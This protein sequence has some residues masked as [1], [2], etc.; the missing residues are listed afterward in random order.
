MNAMIPTQ[1]DERGPSASADADGPSGAVDTARVE[2]L[3]RELLLALGEDPERAGLADTPRRVAGWWREFLEPGSAGTA[4]CFA[5]AS[6]DGQLVVVGDMGVWSLCEHHLLPM[7][8]DVTVGYLPAGV[9]LG[10]SKFGRITRRFAGRLQLQERLTEQV[11]R[12]VIEATGSQDVAVAVRGEHLC[13]S[14]RGVRMGTARTT[15]V[16]TH[17]RFVTDQALSGQFLALSRA[18]GPEGAV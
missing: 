7:R 18:A 16:H 12:A 6:S 9:V 8:L 13:M 3:V 14:M 2:H 17:G 5:E 10:L 15:T 4:T 1:V 11:A